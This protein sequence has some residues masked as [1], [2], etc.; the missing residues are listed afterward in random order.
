MAHK[1]SMQTATEEMARMKAASL[2]APQV[3][4]VQVTKY[5]HSSVPGRAEMTALVRNKQELQKLEKHILRSEQEKKGLRE[6][7]QRTKTGKCGM[8]C[9]C[10]I[11]IIMLFVLLLLYWCCLYTSCT[12]VSVCVCKICITFC[13]F[14]NLLTLPPQSSACMHHCHSELSAT[15]ENLEALKNHHEALQRSSTKTINEL[16]HKLQLVGEEAARSKIAFNMEK[17]KVNVMV[18]VSVHR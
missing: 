18:Y 7:L 12:Y 2:A 14:P 4:H 10:C 13:L 17:H 15:R 3:K 9:V 16:Q 11:Y 1:V 6:G 8:V 5:V